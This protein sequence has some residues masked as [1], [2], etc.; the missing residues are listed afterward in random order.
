MADANFGRLEMWR[1]SLSIRGYEWVVCAWSAGF[2]AV[3]GG[4]GFSFAF[5]SQP[6]A[7]EWLVLWPVW[8]DVQ[9]RS[10]F[11]M[12][13]WNPILESSIIGAIGGFVVAY[14]LLTISHVRDSS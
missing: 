14:V 12:A 9:I 4:I 11:S 10:Q 13:F 2:G 8:L 3:W 7:L 6:T 1:E 5:D